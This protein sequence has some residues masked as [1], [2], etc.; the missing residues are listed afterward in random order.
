M[1]NEI[2]LDSINLTNNDIPKLNEFVV[3]VI[4]QDSNIIN[5]IVSSY[6]LNSTIRTVKGTLCNSSGVPYANKQRTGTGGMTIDHTYCLGGGYSLYYNNMQALVRFQDVGGCLQFDI[7]DLQYMPHLDVFET[8]S[9]KSKVYGVLE[10]CPLFTNNIRLCS[11]RNSNISGDVSCFSE[12][13]R[14]ERLN[15]QNTHISGE[16]ISLGKC[17]HLKQIRVHDTNIT[18]NPDDLADEMFTNGRHS[19]EMSYFINAAGSKYTY[20]FTN[21]G[22]TRG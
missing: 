22:W 12:N 2:V 15:I 20:T 10:S 11:L 13:E 9:T 3:Y 19:G 7:A 4:P 1:T 18:G 14:L 5:D 8:G 6:L 17:I 21:S 16:L